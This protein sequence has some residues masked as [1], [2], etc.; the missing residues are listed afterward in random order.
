MGENNEVVVSIRDLRMSYGDHEVLKS[1]NFDVH[2]GEIIGY[3]GTNGA[4]K[5]TT[6]KILLGLVKGYTGGVKVF[7]RELELSSVDYKSRIGYVPEAADLYDSLT[8]MEYLTFVGELYGLDSKTVET[9]AAKL[10]NIFDLGG[11]VN[12]RISSFSKGMK[13]KVLI[14]ASLIHDPDILLLDEPINGMDANSVIVFK[15]LLWELAQQ[16]KTIF[17]SSHIMEVVERISSRIILLNDGQIAADGTFEELK[18]K[19]SKGSLEQIFNQLTG[20]NK[21]KQIAGEIISA[22]REG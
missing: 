4:G 3:I 20:F 6:V 7:D 9:R 22:L 12:S 21:Q 17:Y 19:C 14:I 10:L 11:V 1:I 8:A 16:G 5:S 2:R 18:D 13:Q 15:E